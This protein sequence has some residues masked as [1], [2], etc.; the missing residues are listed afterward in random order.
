VLVT[1]NRATMPAHLTAHLAQGRHVPGIF[2]VGSTSGFAIIA[3]EL[4]L[5]ATFSLTDD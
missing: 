4:W 5:A 1:N 2:I 3:E